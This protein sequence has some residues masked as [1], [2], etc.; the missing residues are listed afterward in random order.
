MDDFRVSTSSPPS[1]PLRITPSVSPI[2]KNNP[3]FSVMSYNL[4]T[5]SVP[6]ITTFFSRFRH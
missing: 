6:D 5:A 2:F 3:A 1:L 4:T